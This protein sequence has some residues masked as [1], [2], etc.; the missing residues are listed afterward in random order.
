MSKGYDKLN[1]ETD[2][3]RWAS[4]IEACFEKWSDIKIES[5]LDLGCGTGPMTLELCRRGYD[6][7]GLDISCEMLSVAKE[8]ADEQGGIPYTSMPSMPRM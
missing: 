2:Y 4:F 6:M 1:S 3:V 7:T 8:T 5:V